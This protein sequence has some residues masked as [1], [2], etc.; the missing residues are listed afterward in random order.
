ML[1]GTIDLLILSLLIEKDNYGYEISR[2]LKERTE[3][4]FE[5]QEATLYLSLKRLEK[6]QS[7][8]SYWGSETQGGRRKYYRITEEGMER[9]Q[10]I[11]QDWK[12]IAEIVAKFV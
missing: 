7:I 5:V 1:K 4:V 11:K 8:E 12:Q 6:H 9:L 3:G 2:D 10:Q